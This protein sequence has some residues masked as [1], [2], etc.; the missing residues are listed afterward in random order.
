M[1][2]FDIKSEYLYRYLYWSKFIVKLLLVV[3]VAVFV[4][5]M[6]VV[7]VVVGVVVVAE[8]SNQFLD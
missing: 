5:V 4:V 3:V 2:Q 1:N 6:V 8:K 7:V